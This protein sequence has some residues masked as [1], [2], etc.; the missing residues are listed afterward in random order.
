MAKS[1]SQAGTDFITL[2]NDS[3]SANRTLGNSLMNMCI[4]DVLAKGD[5]NFFKDSGTFATGTSVQDYNAPHDANKIEY[6]TLTAGSVKYTPR[7]VRDEESWF[8][9]N[10][11]TITSD[12]PNYWYVSP[13]TKQISLF[14]IPSTRGNIIEIGWTKKTRDLGVADYSTGTVLAT[15]GSTSIAGGGSPSW[16]AKMIGSFIK[17]SNTNTELDDFWLEI[18]DVIGTNR[19]I[20]K[21]QSPATATTASGSYT[22]AEMVPFPDGYENIPLWY[23]LDS[24]YQMRERPAQASWW[25]KKWKEGVEEMERRDIRSVTGVLTKQKPLDFVDPNLNSWGINLTS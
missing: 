10:N 21:E 19:I 20:T 8:L 2:S 5:F 18:K 24:Y 25:E 3:S 7:E 11:V 22:I 17:L 13:R 6:V 23:A 15:L 4:K 16:N 12:I 1:F 9:L 14:P